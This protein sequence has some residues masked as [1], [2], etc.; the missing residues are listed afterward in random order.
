M[1]G[2]LPNMWLGEKPPLIAQPRI[3]AKDVSRIVGDI[4]DEYVNLDWKVVTTHHF[5]QLRVFTTFNDHYNS[6]HGTTRMACHAVDLNQE[7]SPQQVRGLTR[8]LIIKIALQVPF[9]DLGYE[10]D[11]SCPVAI[12]FQAGVIGT[13][14]SSA[15]PGNRAG[16]LVS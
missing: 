3:T 11:G 1:H 7:L 14:V 16:V 6:A 5:A 8:N 2:P 4:V 13:P 9:E 10:G 12:S 15:K